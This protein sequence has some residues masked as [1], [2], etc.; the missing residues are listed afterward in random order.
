MGERTAISWCDH[1]FNAWEGCEKISPGCKFCYAAELNKWLRKGEN[2]GPSTPRRFFGNAHWAKPIAW[3]RAAKEAGVRRRVFCSSVA[4]VFEDH[5]DVEDARER[6]WRLID[7]TPN[8]EWLLLTKRPENVAVMIPWLDDVDYGDEGA[9]ANVWLGVTAENEE[10]ALRRLPEQRKLHDY[11]AKLFVSYEPA[12]GRI[13]WQRHF[14]H[15]VRPDW[16]IFG[17]ESGRSRRPAELDWA[18]ETRDAC[19]AAGVAFHFKQWCGD[20]AP[21]LEGERT[22]RRKIHLPLLDGVQHAAFP[23]VAP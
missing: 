10:W 11:F 6:L 20:D 8:L 7:E 16:V 23:E 14:A 2:W 18:R 5:P 15:D 21:G 9:P 3:D 19:A 12:L 13:D 22:K 4:D 17:D 1:T